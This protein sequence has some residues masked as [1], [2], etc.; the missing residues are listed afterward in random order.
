MKTG[1]GRVRPPKSSSSSL[2]CCSW[3]GRPSQSGFGLD[4]TSDRSQDERPGIM[5]ERPAS[6]GGRHSREI[7]V[8]ARDTGSED[9]S[10]PAHFAYPVV[11]RSSGVDRRCPC[12]SCRPFHST[13]RTDDAAPPCP[14]EPTQKCRRPPSTRFAGCQVRSGRTSISPAKTSWITRP[15]CRIVPV[16]ATEIGTF[17]STHDGRR[18]LR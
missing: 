4:F 8:T 2:P 5:D 12:A 18:A 15:P 14:G 6:R 10:P 3:P 9:R 1:D 11:G 16:K 13:V 17:M 7:G